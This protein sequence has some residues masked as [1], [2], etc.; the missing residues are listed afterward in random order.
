MKGNRARMLEDD[1]KIVREN[2]HLLPPEER[3][4]VEQLLGDTE[5]MEEDMDMESGLEEE[6]IEEEARTREQEV[7]DREE[8]AAKTVKAAEGQKK[9]APKKKPRK[10]IV[11]ES[12][13]IEI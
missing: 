5:G 6:D 4:K 7:V 10:A 3:E 13:D 12:M 2:Q 11:G 8:A 1:R 9:R